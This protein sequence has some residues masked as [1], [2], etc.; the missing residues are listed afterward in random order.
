MTHALREACCLTAHALPAPIARQIALTAVVALGLSGKPFHEPFHAQG[1]LSGNPGLLC[2]TSM[3]AH[4]ATLSGCRPD[5]GSWQ[6][7]LTRR[8]CCIILLHLGMASP[9]LAILLSG[10][11]SNRAKIAVKAVLR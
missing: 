9:V 8:G 1:P 6:P 4:R 5:D 3:T 11:G 2:I 7:L 10:A